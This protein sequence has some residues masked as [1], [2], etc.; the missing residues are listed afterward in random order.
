[1]TRSVQWLSIVIFTIMR[2]SA[3]V[4][5]NT[6]KYDK[7]QQV[8][9]PIRIGLALDDHSQKDMIV[10]MNAVHETAVEP[11]SLVFHIVAVGKDMIA[12]NLLKHSLEKS[13][14]SCLPDVG[15]EVKAFVLPPDSGFSLQLHKAKKK[16]HWNSNS[17]ADMVRFYLASLFPDVDRI[18]YLD[19]DIIVSCCLE[20]IWD[21]DL[22][23]RGV[24]GIALDDLKWAT[25][26]Q[27]KYH[28]N[29]T[30][31]LVIRNMRR[32]ANNMSTSGKEAASILAAGSTISKENSGNS[33][34][35]PHA[36]AK[37][38]FSKSLPRYPNDG[39]LLIDVKRW[40]SMKIL[41]TMD[42]IAMANG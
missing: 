27:F 28:Y 7:L 15:V 5:I 29:A 37:E 33:A 13:I 23:D 24:V 22:G 41:E 32:V 8:I 42:E 35:D 20:E 1:M 34:V 19:N 10:L 9:R 31:P 30:H 3:G 26:T 2:F 14:E 11:D 12:S 17:G 25:Q 16:S 6:A 36:L 38:E 4:Y 39:V 18:L 21:T 40:N